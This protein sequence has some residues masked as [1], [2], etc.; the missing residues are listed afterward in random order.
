MQISQLLPEEWA[1]LGWKWVTSL[2]IAEAHSSLRHFPQFRR[3]LQVDSDFSVH[4]EHAKQAWHFGETPDWCWECKWH[5]LSYA[6]RKGSECVAIPNWKGGTCW[7]S[8]SHTRKP[9]CWEG[10]QKRSRRSRWAA[11]EALC[12]QRILAVLHIPWIQPP[13]IFFPLLQKLKVT[14]SSQSATEWS[15]SSF[16]LMQPSKITLWV[17]T[18]TFLADERSTYVCN[19]WLSLNNHRK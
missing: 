11:Q 9:S 19:K 8:T 3:T 17:V 7:W 15:V 18:V 1:V 10:R 16:I 2:G 13:L 5:L 14:A 12:L 4:A 6:A